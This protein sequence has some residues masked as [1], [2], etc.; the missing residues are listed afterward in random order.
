MKQRIIRRLGDR[1]Q[2]T[3]LV[4]RASNAS[5][6]FTRGV[7]SADERIRHIERIPLIEVSRSNRRVLLR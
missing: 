7:S 6:P 3:C 4:Q 2:P 1:R 5:L